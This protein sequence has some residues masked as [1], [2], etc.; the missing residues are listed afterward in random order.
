MAKKR[1]KRIY[2]F[3]ASNLRYSDFEKLINQEATT[4][5]SFYLE[6]SENK[7]EKKNSNLRYLYLIKNV[8]L[9]FLVRLSPIRRLIYSLAIILFIW[10]YFNG[11]NSWLILSFVI[12]NLLLFFEVAEKLTATEELDIA[13]NIQENLL[14]KQVPKIENLDISFY[15]ETAKNVGGDYLDIISSDEKNLFF[16][17]DISG[18]GMGAALYM[19]QVRALIH[20]IIG[21]NESLFTSLTELN[22]ILCKTFEKKYFFTLSA[23]SIKNNSVDIYRAGHLPIIYYS[24]K[25]KKST[26]IIPSGI[27]LGL[28]DSKIFSNSLKKHKIGLEEND[29]LVI[30]SD[31]LTETMNIEK[32]EF[33]EERLIKVIELAAQR[34]SEGIKKAILANIQLFRGN[35]E[36]YDD[37]SVVII[38]ASGLLAEFTVSGA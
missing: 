11:F 14:P 35:C 29:I 26:K 4:V 1:I 32:S 10:G 33:G 6:N 34:D 19:V 3:Y 12:I 20:Y 25:E 23:V 24:A 18:K 15:S 13:K 28:T 9:A 17:G 22:S 7:D 21:K 8:F 30:Y 36:P 5:F 31:G 37:V 2:D 38:K 27:G 16:V